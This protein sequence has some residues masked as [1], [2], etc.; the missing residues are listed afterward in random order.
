MSDERKKQ[1]L[2]ILE[3]ND[4]FCMDEEDER[5][6]LATILARELFGE[7]PDEEPEE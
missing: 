5:E 1:I 2:A 4:G 7:V 6:A 3:Q